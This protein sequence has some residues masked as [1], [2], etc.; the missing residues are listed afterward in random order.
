MPDFEQII[1]GIN[2]V[3]GLI[4]GKNVPPWISVLIG[5]A[6]AFCLLLC[7]LWGILFVLSKIKDLWMQ[8]FL[9][10][11][12][13]AEQKQNSIR[14]QYFAGHIEHEIWRLGL[15]EE[16]K[17]YRFAELEA[18]VEAEGSHTIFGLLPFLKRTHSGR[19][20]E[21][22]LSKALR[23]NQE[24]LILVEGEPGSGK[25]IALRHVAQAMAANAKK[26][27]STK[28]IIPIYVNLKELERAENANID[29]KLIEEFVLKCLKRINDRDVDQFL[30][31]KFDEGIRNGLWFFLFDSFD[32]LPEVL[33]S[34]EVDTVIKDYGNAIDA[35]LH[36]MNQCRGVIASRQ[37]RGPNYFGWPCFHILPLSESRCLQLIRKAELTPERANEFIGHLGNARQEIRSMVSNPL[38]LNLL[39]EYVKGGKSFPENTHVVFENYI[40]NRLTRDEERLQKRFNLDTT[41]MRAT[42][43]HIAFCMAA[44]SGLGLNPTRE[45]LQIA[46]K[47]QN[48]ELIG[49]LDIFLEALAFIKLARYE[50]VE[51]SSQLRT[52]TF[53]HR[54]FQEYFATCIVLCE[55]FRV[56]T[57]QLLMDARWR[58]TAVAM[59]QT[60]PK[61]ELTQIV[62]EAQLLLEGF[63][64][65]IEG[66]IDNPVE[67]VLIND[68][69][70]S[71]RVR[72]ADEQIIRSSFYWPSGSLHLLS[73]L[74]DGFISHLTDLPENI[75]ITASKLVISASSMGMLFDRKWALEVSG[76]IPEPVL[77]YL[78]KD[79]FSSQSEWLKE[80][81]YRRAACLSNISPSIA[82]GIREG[83]LELA[84]ANRL[85]R[86]Q[87]ATKAY[88]SRIEYSNQF[89]A[90]MNLLLW[91]P[92]I[93]L[94]IY[95]LLFII[96]SLNL[97]NYDITTIVLKEIFLII[98]LYISHCTLKIFMRPSHIGDS[99]FKFFLIG[100]KRRKTHFYDIALMVYIRLLLPLSIGSSFLTQIFQWIPVKS[101]YYLLNLNLLIS[102][103]ILL[104][105]PLAI[106]AIIEGTFIKFRWWIFLP[107]WPL[108]FLIM[109]PVSTT[110][111]LYK[112]MTNIKLK[113]M[114]L[115]IFVL[116]ILLTIT[117][118]FVWFII[119]VWM[120]YI[121]KYYPFIYLSINI[122][123]IIILV[124]VSLVIL[125]LPI[126]YWMQD[127]FRFHKWHKNQNRTDCN[128][129]YKYS[130]EYHYSSF[131]SKYLRTV[132]ER[133]LLTPSKDAELYFVTLITEMEAKQ[134]LNEKNKVL[135]RQNSSNLL[136]SK[137]K[138][139]GHLAENFKLIKQIHPDVIDEMNML[140]EDIRNG[141]QRIEI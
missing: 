54:R 47:R 88:L 137:S 4:F 59:F 82:K 12:Y 65:E 135:N 115:L 104:F 101:T 22:S 57:K 66:L 94:F 86:E 100:T 93:E 8:N 92:F 52:F 23:R 99:I 31:D 50:E 60:Q 9:P 97:G 139:T 13:S 102:I 37:F 11:F 36:R 71:K 45:N 119:N 48:M 55:P 103:Y 126:F 24:R 64:N 141:S 58:E 41:Q 62:K 131:Y 42:A 7:G 80:V 53:A 69:S 129:I 81:A 3:L 15:K 114:T 106:W 40:N 79:A 21:K 113:D 70:E 91:L 35:F 122:L 30:D 132:R 61:E 6:L 77:A 29:W 112:Q 90:V 68:L 127:W 34:T 46:L 124:I 128:E 121:S 10:L 44:D 76:I 28:S 130:N 107:I 14:R 2:A 5:W 116:I 85:R 18:E 95:L 17:D 138:N 1:K 74:Q 118:F 83:I 78:L 19:R 96:I 51:N 105:S 140:L 20:L 125:T 49:N 43:E 87:L 111:L 98:I 110:K 84:A 89:F 67:Y 134:S 39:C 63:C 73:L 38:F 117:L 16:W 25:S 136:S 72:G 26:S 56:S 27:K 108:L 109:H 32:E 120:K 75:K 33:S 133:H 123:F